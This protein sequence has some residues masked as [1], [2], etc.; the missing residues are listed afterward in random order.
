MLSPPAPAGGGVVAF[1]V[2]AS[3]RGDTRLRG[4]MLRDTATG[5]DAELFAGGVFVFVGRQRRSL[6]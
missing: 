2:V 6:Q 4:V 5:T 3:L 1:E